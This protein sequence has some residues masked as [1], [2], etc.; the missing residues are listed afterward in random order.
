[1]SKG[2]LK[3]RVGT[4]LRAAWVGEK[5][6]TSFVIYVL[7]RNMSSAAY[8]YI[9]DTSLTLVGTRLN[10]TLSVTTGVRN[11]TTGADESAVI[12]DL[13]NDPLVWSDADSK[14]W[15][16]LRIR[17]FEFTGLKSGTAYTMEP[18][19][20]AVSANDDTQ[21]RLAS[22]QFTVKTLSA[23]VLT[24]AN[25]A[26]DLNRWATDSYARWDDLGQKPT[27]F[28]IQ[29]KLANLGN[30]M[31]VCQDDL[32]YSDSP[33]VEGQENWVDPN[34]VTG[35]TITAYTSW[36]TAQLTAGEL[37]AGATLNVEEQAT[38]YTADFM[39]V[40]WF[41]R[42]IL[43][44]ATLINAM[45]SS[46]ESTDGGDHAAMKNN[47][48]FHFT[49]GYTN[50]LLDG[51][52][53]DSYDAY[54]S[55]GANFKTDLETIGT[56]TLNHKLL[57]EYF[58]GRATGAI[59]PAILNW[60]AMYSEHADFG[61]TLSLDDFIAKPIY[62]QKTHPLVDIFYLNA[63]YYSDTSA[64][65]SG[66]APYPTVAAPSV[67]KTLNTAQN[68]WL[69]TQIAASTKP[70]III[71][72]GDPLLKVDADLSLSTFGYGQ[73]DSMGEKSNTELNDLITVLQAETGKGILVLT[74][75][76]HAAALSWDGGNIVQAV[77]VAAN[78]IL[79]PFSGEYSNFTAQHNAGMGF[80]R[81]VVTRNR[82]SVYTVEISDGTPVG[83]D[84]AYFNAGD[85][86][87]T[88]QSRAG[89]SYN[90]AVA[91]GNGLAAL[92]VN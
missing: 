42:M 7:T 77:A 51:T 84:V 88:F 61:T 68:D 14:N 24:G 21:G 66:S 44:P 28:D 62:R 80:N 79:R 58:F 85:S 53:S 40:A 78:L 29:E 45:Q 22:F 65:L 55:G 49:D 50:L 59:P 91:T 38:T 23:D 32:E 76:Y 33:A 56:M 8:N 35:D 89:H 16:G 6:T 41:F 73:P 82:M 64:F 3:G 48:N 1:M 69:A 92:Q 10:K 90:K 57:Y 39:L 12:A 30:D 83:S 31:T 87:W 54:T 19:T 67:N 75:D 4:G 34:T 2:Y 36:P 20:D 63:T 70:F 71:F 18:Y 25:Y 17:R 5:T 11:I 60:R 86:Q 13:E 15:I 74:G 26:C 37:W 27:W 9:H 43:H 47:T 81:F 52:Y 46:M 72:C